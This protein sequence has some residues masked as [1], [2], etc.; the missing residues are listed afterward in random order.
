MRRPRSARCHH[1]LTPA[2]SATPRAL[3]PASPL[4][5]D[6]EYNLLARLARAIQDGGLSLLRNAFAARGLAA[7]GA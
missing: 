4:L 6:P 3:T 2:G 5:A 1:L 7:A